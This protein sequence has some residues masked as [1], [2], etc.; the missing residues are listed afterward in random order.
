MVTFEVVPVQSAIADLVAEV[1]LLRSEVKVL[2]EQVTEL[3]ALL[4]ERPTVRPALLTMVPGI[5]LVR[6]ISIITEEYPEYCLARMP[7]IEAFGEG[8]TEAEAI[9]MLG[10]QVAALFVDL[11]SAGDD[12]LGPLPRAW[13][14]LL[15]G[16]LIPNA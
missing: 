16:V 6:P 12:E 7:E 15:N 4:D 14:D 5:R 10:K 13:R 3:K 8:D 1:R 9:V 11:Q 2:Q